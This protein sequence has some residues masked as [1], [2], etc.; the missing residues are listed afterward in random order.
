MLSLLQKQFMAKVKLSDREIEELYRKGSYNLTQEKNDFLLPQIQDFVREKRWMNLN[1]EYQRRMI[2]DVNRK[3]LFIESLLMNIPIPPVFLFEW[4]YS[5]YEVMDG[6]QR[7]STIIAFYEYLFRLKGLE[8]WSV[9][10]G[11][12]YSECPPLIRRGLDR[13]RISAT[14]VLAE[15]VFEKNDQE[16]MH[17]LVFERLNTGG[18]KLNPQ[19]LRNC[20]FSGS[21]NDLILELAGNKL[22]NDTWGIPRYEDNIIDGEVN[23]KLSSN[24]Y[25]KRM[26]DCEI[27]LRFFAFRQKKYVRGSIKKILDNCMIRNRNAVES[28]IDSL[29]QRFISRLHGAYEI[30]GTDTF[31]IKDNNGKPK[32]SLPMFDAVMVAVD[33]NYDSL[34][35]LVLHRE[36]IKDLLKER[37]KDQE[38]FE[39]L[40]G[41]VGTAKSIIERAEAVSEI[42]KTSLTEGNV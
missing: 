37:I 33:Q 31:I 25:Y 19:E 36:S 39:L 6:Q 1:P 4:D 27:V 5:I 12:T 26:V 14:V 24:T 17:Q 35:Q 22:F 30:F 41:K 40:T 10:N 34:D 13:R 23:A 42:F 21:F 29:R 11:R 15:S 9:L 16:S 32:R 7:L 38:Y 20:L 3:S 8:K 28:E 2:W 18:M